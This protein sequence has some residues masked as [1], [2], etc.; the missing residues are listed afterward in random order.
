MTTQTQQPLHFPVIDRNRGWK[1]LFVVSFLVV[2]LGAFVVA[3]RS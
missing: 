1:D 3:G 2:V